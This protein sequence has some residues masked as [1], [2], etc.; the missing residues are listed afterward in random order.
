VAQP[1]AYGDSWIGGGGKV[2]PNPSR[3]SNTVTLCFLAALIFIFAALLYVPR[4]HGAEP[5]KTLVQLQ[6]MRRH[7]TDKDEPEL[8]RAERLGYLAGAIDGVARDALE[9][10]VLLVI[11]RGESGLA[12]FVDLDWDKCR[13]G[14]QGWCDSGRAYGVAQ[15]HGMLRTETRA[16]QMREA[17]KRWRYHRQRCGSV[18]GAFAGYGS[19]N[20]CTLTAQSIE[21]AKSAERLARKL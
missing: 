19:G 14:H 17:L 7:H 8:D 2:I 20:S 10:A 9:R 5:S 1:G 16:E 13:E 4:A 11:V 6:A 18:A 15:L 21:R 3:D 12:R